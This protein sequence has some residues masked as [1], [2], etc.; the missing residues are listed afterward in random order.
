MARQSATYFTNVALMSDV[1]RGSSCRWVV[2]VF[3]SMRMVSRRCSRTFTACRSVSSDRAQL[4]GLD[5][6]P[7]Q[8]E[9]HEVIDDVRR[10]DERD[11]AA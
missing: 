7:S 2:S 5:S 6:A 11:R 1:S 9:W 10:R 8:H 3:N 4:E